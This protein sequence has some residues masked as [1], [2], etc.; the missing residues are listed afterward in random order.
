LATGP[1]R[2]ILKEITGDFV[3]GSPITKRLANVTAMF[4]GGVT[5]SLTLDAEGVKAANIKLQPLIQASKGFWGEVHYVDGAAL[6]VYFDPKEDRIDP[7][8]AA[9]AEKGALSDDRVRVQSS[10]LIVVG[11]SAFLANANMTEADLDFVLNSINWLIDREEIIGIAPKPVRNLALSLTESQM[12]TIALLV[13]IAIPACAAAIG[14][15][16]WLKRR[17]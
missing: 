6:G 9:S 4:K 5:Q 2:G 12:G 13:M 14:V 11:S 10:R 17:R 15:L 16:V 3:A 1:A 7:V 8:V